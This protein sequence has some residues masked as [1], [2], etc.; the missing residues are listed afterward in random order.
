MT[1]EPF[2]ILDVS[3][4]PVVRTVIDERT[5][6]GGNAVWMAEMD[7]LLDAAVPFVLISSRRHDRESVE[8][9]RDRASWYRDRRDRLGAVC[10]GMIHIEPDPGRRAAMIA[11]TAGFDTVVKFPFTIAADE[12]EAL[13]AADGYLSRGPA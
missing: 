5:A 2:L 7:R 12:K 8:E 11:E 9:A 10:R 13:A 6:A 3:G 1:S 4:F